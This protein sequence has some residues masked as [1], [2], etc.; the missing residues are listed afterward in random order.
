MISHIPKKYTKVQGTFIPIFFLWKPYHVTQQI[1]KASD[2]EVYLTEGTEWEKSPSSILVK[3]WCTL[4]LIAIAGRLF[5]GIFAGIYTGSDMETEQLDQ[6]SEL[7]FLD[8]LTI[9]FQALMIISTIL[10]I[11]II[12]QI[13]TWQNQ[14]SISL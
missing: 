11:R 8:L 5:F 2:P 3:Q 14:K 4:Y 1:W 10:F 12:R 9:P 13:S 6:S 7:T